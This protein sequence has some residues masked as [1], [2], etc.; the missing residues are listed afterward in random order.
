MT[1]YIPYCLTKLITV[2]LF[3]LP[4][5]YL[6][7]RNIKYISNIIF[8]AYFVIIVENPNTFRNQYK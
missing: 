4:T 8:E 7:C 5:Y 2:T 3:V 1:W 6:T